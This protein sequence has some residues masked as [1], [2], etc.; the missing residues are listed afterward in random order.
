[1]DHGVVFKLLMSVGVGMAAAYGV[2]GSFKKQYPESASKYTLIVGVGVA[3]LTAAA[4]IY[5]NL[6]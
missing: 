1:M 3:V 4:R 6:Y 5:F 2:Y